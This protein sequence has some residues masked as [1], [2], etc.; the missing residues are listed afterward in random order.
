MFGM[1]VAAKGMIAIVMFFMMAAT[2]IMP[3][4]VGDSNPD[5]SVKRQP[6]G[7]PSVNTAWFEWNA[8]GNGQVHLEIHNAGMSS[9]TIAICENATEPG[10]NV[11]QETI[12]FRHDL[13][14]TF[15]SGSVDVDDGVKYAF[16][17]T[18]GGPPESGGDLYVV[19]EPDGPSSE[20]TYKI[21]N[22]FEE[23]WDE[24]WNIR[25]GGGWDTERL[26]TGDEGE[27]SYLYSTLRK[28]TG[29]G[30]D[31]GL[32]YAPYRWNIDANAIPNLNVHDPVFIPK[33]GSSDVSGAEAS[34]SVYFQYLYTEDGD[35]L[36]L[37]V[38][39][40][41]ETG[42]YV[43]GTIE[44]DAGSPSLWQTA[45]EDNILFYNDGY[46][47]GTIYEISMNREAAEEWLGLDQSEEDPLTWW[48]DAKSD[49]IAD[50]DAWINDQGNV[51]FD[52]YCGYEYFYTGYGTMMTLSTD[53]DNVVLKIAHISQG[54][55]ALMT[56]WLS[57]T[58]VSAHQ[59]YMEDFTMTVVYRAT[60]VNLDLDAVAQ[61]SLHCVK[62]N[63][64]EVGEDA[65]CAW[66][67]EPIALDYVA[68]FGVHPSDY[69]PY[70]DLT[71][72]SW[73][74]GDVQYSGEVPYEGTPVE[75][76]LSVGMKLVVVLPDSLVIGYH[77]EEVPVDAIYEVWENGNLG[78]YVALQYYGEMEL[79]Y[80]VLNE[81]T[82]VYDP[83]SRT[84]TIEGP[85]DFENP[86][87][88][89]ESLLNHGAPWLE[90][91]VNPI[92]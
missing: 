54:Y 86:H 11:W 18:P 30:D 42:A 79:G 16:S 14:G 70:S 34:M 39:E 61:W 74:C 31:Q 19:F 13:T 48:A 49:M 60:D 25:A 5:F 29:E 58:G 36:D 1:R 8:P 64:A 72:T 53:G 68:A 87:D 77:A 82:Y 23:E 52:I 10:T 78:D 51:V 37:W 41:G 21:Y 22:M 45:V 92:A 85:A 9:V 33:A 15:Y 28:P 88:D 4:A 7:A 20:I 63:D 26:L 84:L 17:A 56:R 2:A 62:Q 65:L 32:I 59:P 43:D 75:M 55:E 44:G 89:D 38:P 12:R 50:F 27:V 57:H 35:W 24:W 66:A 91:N 46:M 71:Y 81:N 67:W 90:F 6:P 40:W 69:T 83:M 3:G 76:D 80:M 73:N 47:M